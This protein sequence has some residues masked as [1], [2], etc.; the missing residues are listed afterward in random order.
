MSDNATL[1]RSRN[2]RYSRNLGFMGELPLKPSGDA[3]DYRFLL[4][5]SFHRPIAVRVT[6]DN[7]GARVVAVELERIG[8]YEFVKVLRRQETELTTKQVDEF[9]SSLETDGLW[10]IPSHDDERGRHILDGAEWVI[11]ASTTE[12]RV[13]TRN[14]PRNDTVRVMGERFLAIAGWTSEEVY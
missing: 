10:S 8:G 2:D 11:E 3:R 1:D 7:V 4:L 5:R 6:R 13:I 12:Y 14:S 9:E